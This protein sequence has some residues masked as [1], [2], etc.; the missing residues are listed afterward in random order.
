MKNRSLRKIELLHSVIERNLFLITGK[1]NYCRLL[2]AIEDLAVEVNEY[3][4]E[5]DCLWSIGEFSHC[6]C[7]SL[8]IGLYWFFTHN[9]NG[10]SSAEYRI[11]CII[12]DIY[13]PGIGDIESE[14]FQAI[15]VYRQMTEKLR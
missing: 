3:I 11:L 10:Q 5:T 4:G 1:L 12:G 8:L 15:E 7:D 14:C 6:S 2:E 9:Y 13:S